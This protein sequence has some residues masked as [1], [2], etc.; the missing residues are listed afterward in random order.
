MGGGYYDGDVGERQRSTRE[1][2]FTF[3]GYGMDTES[4]RREVHEELN[5]KNQEKECADSEEH[6]NTTPIVVAMDVTRSR[7]DDAKVVYGK[8]PM[9]I[10][11]II[12]KGYV[13]NPVIS[14]AAIGDA[15]SGDSAPIQVGQFESDN[16]L[17]DVLSKIWLEEGGG[18]TG[19]E[20]YEL[21]AYYYAKH[22]ALDANK[23]GKKGY[24]FF[25]GD[26]GFYPEVAKDQ[27]KEWIG[28][29]VRANIP[30]EKVFKE[31]QEKYH[32]FFIYP[33]KT[34]EE[35]KVD[36]DAEIKKRLDEA[37]GRYEN[38][39]FRASLIW[40]TFDDLDL[41]VM[42]KPDSGAGQSEHIAY[43]NRHSKNG[44]GE[45]DVDR[46]AGRRETRKPVENIRWEK[47][48]AP[49]GKYTVFVRNYALHDDSSYREFP[50]EFKVE[51]EINGKIQTF[52]KTI[53]RETVAQGSSTGPNRS[54]VVIGE[55]NFDP[56]ERSSDDEIYAGYDDQLIKNQWLS[57]IPEEN[58]LIIDD[59][60]A[61]VDVMMGALA[62]VEGNI[63]LDGYLIDMTGRGQTERRLGQT[64]KA[65]RNLAET[66]AL[67]RVETGMLPQK[68]LGKRRKS[69]STR[70]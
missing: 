53:A 7:G 56:N 62:L 64:E 29:N 55:F 39:D 66:K 5:P 47:G 31:L 20:S 43:D 23:R 38:I 48:S 42:L 27:I 70:L 60:K 40:N 61:I 57:V 41:H 4:D 34:W 12:M 10:G 26:E 36:I 59:P 52:K 65:L 45:L 21:M 15:T 58:L 9:F 11:Q 50:I 44:Q 22:S 28:D 25:V 54:D 17:D 33:K 63:D 8:L 3:E 13:P 68:N 24:F 49:K 2:H 16:R 69:K 35:R 51:I 46:N 37:G 1:E 32:V 6:P 67:T 19:Q 14:F 18:G 30:S